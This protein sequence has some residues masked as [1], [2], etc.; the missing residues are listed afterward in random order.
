[1]KHTLRMRSGH[2]GEPARDLCVRIPGLRQVIRQ[3]MTDH[4]AYRE[5]L[6]S[7]GPGVLAAVEETDGEGTPS[8]VVR[9]MTTE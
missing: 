8:S 2:D 7:F 6:Q 1:M 9:T 4:P 5:W 3:R